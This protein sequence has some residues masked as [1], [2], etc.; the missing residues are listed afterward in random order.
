MKVKE[1]KDFLKN[2]PDD[3]DIMM[4]MQ[5]ISYNDKYKNYYEDDIQKKCKPIIYTYNTLMF[6]EE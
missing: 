3:Y 2:V 4:E 1:L 6:V 5:G